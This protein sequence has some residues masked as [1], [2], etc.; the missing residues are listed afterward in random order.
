[1]ETNNKTIYVFQSKIGDGYLGWEHGDKFSEGN[2]GIINNCMQSVRDWAAFHNFTHE[3]NT[4]DL[5]W[6]FRFN[7]KNDVQLNRLLQNWEHIPKAG[8]D[9]I[10]YLDNDVFVNDPAS[11]PPLVDFGMAPRYGDQ[12]LFAKHYFGEDSLWFNSGVV[13]MSRERCNH[14]SQWILSRIKSLNWGGLFE[15]LP[16]EESFIAEYCS[17]IKPTALDF[18]WNTMPPQTPTPL[19]GNVKLLHLLGTDKSRILD[20]CSPELQFNVRNYASL[21]QGN[22]NLGCGQTATAE[23]A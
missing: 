16:R 17:A 8:Y 14:L 11:V 18:C 9:F 3:L 22:I 13:I 19:Y 1:M 12:V 5:G 6:D 20:M 2:A 15:D 23:Y 21:G 10:I 4:S 7:S